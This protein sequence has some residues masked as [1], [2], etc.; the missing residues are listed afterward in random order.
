M[1]S[2]FIDNVMICAGLH[3]MD[4]EHMST[5]MTALPSLRNLTSLCLSGTLT[6]F[7]DEAHCSR[8]CFIF[9]FCEPLDFS[10]STFSAAFPRIL[11]LDIETFADFY[12][13][14]T[15][16]IGSALRNMPQLLELAIE[17]KK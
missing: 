17:S 10:V 14:N 2:D 7:K 11:A 15:L 5:L 12:L 13:D 3:S 4:E 16:V 9:D 1:L 6:L 8:C